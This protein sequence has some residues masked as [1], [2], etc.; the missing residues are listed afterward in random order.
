MATDLAIYFQAQRL[1]RGLRLGQLARLLGYRNV[2][3]RAHRIVRFEREGVIN[4]PL[5]GHL[6]GVLRVDVHTVAQL[7][8]QDR[9]EYLWAWEA[10]VNELVPRTWSRVDGDIFSDVN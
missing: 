10:W 7:I 9:Q 6:A 3:K 4:E 2:T 1:A 8:E 5:L